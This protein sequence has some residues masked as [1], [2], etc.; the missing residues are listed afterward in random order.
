MARPR[1]ARSTRNVLG[2]KGRRSSDV[3]MMTVEI[4]CHSERSAEGAESRNRGMA[5]SWG[6]SFRTNAIP[7]LR[8]RYA[9]ASLGMTLVGAIDVFV[10]YDSVTVRRGLNDGFGSRRCTATGIVRHANR[11]PGGLDARP[12]S[13][14]RFLPALLRGPGGWALRQRAPGGVQLVLRGVPRRRRA[15]GDHDATHPRRPALAAGARLRPRRYW[16]RLSRRCR[17]AHR[18]NGGRWRAD[19]V[20]T[21]GDGG[22]VL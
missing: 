19:R 12:R 11:P 14:A 17:S 7:R 8:V 1:R 2:G 6:L 21:A 4:G 5:R 18:T 13:A 16:C 3:V 9:R 20:A 15:P 22:R 10:I